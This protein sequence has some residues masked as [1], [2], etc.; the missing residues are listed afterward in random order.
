MP[1]G[2]LASFLETALCWSAERSDRAAQTLIRSPYSGIESEV[3]AAIATLAQRGAADN[4]VLGVIT[5]GRLAV[6]ADART[7]LIEFAGKLKRIYTAAQN[8]SCAETV[9]LIRAEFSLPEAD[10][11]VPEIATKFDLADPVKPEPGAS[12]RSRHAHFS[13]SSLNTYAECAR[14]WFYRYLC[15]AVEDKGSSASFYGTAFHDALETL[16]KEF[17][18][19][20]GVPQQTLLT[21][22]QGYLNVSFDRHR[23]GFETAVEFEL[24]RRR[25]GRTGRRYVEWLVSESARAPFTVLG[26]EVAA[27]LDLEGFNFIGYIDRLDRDAAGGVAVIDYKTG[28]IAQSANAYREKVRQ[29]KDFQLPFYYWARTALGDRVSKL[30]LLP[31]KDALLEVVPI[32]LEVVPVALAEGRRDDRPTGLISIAELESAKKRM[33]EICTELTDGSISHFAVTDSAEA[34]RYCAYQL[35]CIDRPPAAQEKFGR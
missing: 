14:K 18:E 21:K 7:A 34:C 31:L 10:S 4:G 2:E 28:A 11:A 33:I 32:S 9:K 12:L 27:Q 23:T 13:A 35:A 3:G 25:A 6:P 22:L 29:F 1:S 19:P 8:G 26:C 30:A 20:A 17:P 16:H 15:A 24:Q 5:A